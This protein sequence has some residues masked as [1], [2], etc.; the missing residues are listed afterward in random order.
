MVIAPEPTLRDV[1]RARRAALPVPE[2]IAAAMAVVERVLALPEI[3]GA[4]TVAGYW[5]VAGELP[6]L[7]LVARLPATARYCLPMLQPGRV[8]RF[9]PWRAG[10]PIVANRYGIPEP[11]HPG[12]PIDPAQLDV[13]VVPLLGFARDGHRIGSG[14]GWYDRS[15]AFRRD[16]PAPP[17][18]VGVGF[19]CQDVGAHVPQPWDVPLDVLVT[20]RETLVFAR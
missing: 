14:G 10:D 3:R 20:E 8:L 18:L 13:V 4:R 1:L 11:A 12:A 19:A 9:A 6:L 2:K 15:F 7:G 17:L 16:A 5:A